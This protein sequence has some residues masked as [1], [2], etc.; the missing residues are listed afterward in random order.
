LQG[1]PKKRS[2]QMR[3]ADEWHWCCQWSFPDSSCSGWECDLLL[4][5]ALSPTSPDTHD[6]YACA[7]PCSWD[8]V[9]VSPSCHR[10]ASFSSLLVSW[11]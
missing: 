2:E 7:C 3:S 6:R 4:S 5:I 1:Q 10:W 11:L 9:Q 8:A